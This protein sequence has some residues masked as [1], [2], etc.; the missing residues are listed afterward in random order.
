MAITGLVASGMDDQGELGGPALRTGEQS[1]NPHFGTK[2]GLCVIKV[3]TAA[4]AGD[5]SEAE[6]PLVTVL[7]RGFRRQVRVTPILGLSSLATGGVVLCQDPCGWL[8]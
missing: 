4:T 2:M 1:Q 7:C 5:C 8:K 6:I 3:T